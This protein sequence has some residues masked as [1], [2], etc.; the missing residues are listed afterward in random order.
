MSWGNVKLPHRQSGTVLI[1]VILIA[2]FVI[3]LVVESTKTVRYQKQLSS[4]LI[5]RDQAYS[6]LMG[7]EELAKIYLKKAF[8]NTKDENVHLN[9]PWAQEN[10]TFPIDGGVMTASIKDM[11]SCFN[12]NSILFEGENNNNNNS[13]R[14]G[15]SPQNPQNPKSGGGV[16]PQTGQPIGTKG[17][18]ILEELISQV[19]ENTEI[20]PDELAT[21]VRDWIDPDI[22]PFDHRGA[23]DDYYQAMEI[24]YRSANALISHTSELLAMKG[25]SQKLY[26]G[27]TPYICVLPEMDVDQVNVNTVDEESALL[28]K[29]VLGGKNISTS[30]ITRAMSGRGEK[31]FSNV[32][33]FIDELGVTNA[34]KLGQDKLTVTSN[35]FQVSAQAEIGK[36]RVAMKT[37]FKKSGDNNFEVVSRYYG[38]E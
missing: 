19:N 35:Y 11:Q 14:G 24:P 5:N 27:L 2:A 6:Y 18:D 25:F 9:Q 33:D 28:L 7:M 32:K 21:V 36:T 10:I 20:Q 29:A 26:L 16:N 31:G 4:N 34:D 23:E 1:T 13:G 15:Q 30:D 38:K 22:E 8:E 3:I 12:I 37:L 17:Q